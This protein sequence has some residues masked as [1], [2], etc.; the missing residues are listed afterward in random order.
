[1]QT[2]E[3]AAVAGQLNEIADLLEARHENEF[4]V[5]AYRVAART[6][7][8][9]PQPVSRLAARGE[10][11]LQELPGIGAHLARVIKQ[12]AEQGYTG[13]I[14][15]LVDETPPEAVLQLVPTIGPKLAQRF[16]D[17]LGVTTLAELEKA[18]ASGKVARM[19]GL[20]T[21]R[22]RALE[23]FFHDPKHA[24]APVKRPVPP[25][26]ELLDI[27]A[28][29]RRRAQDGDLPKLAPRR[30]NPEHT[31]WLPVLH[32]KRAG[33]RYTALYSNTQRAHEL[34]KEHDWVVI[35]ADDDDGQWTVVTET[36]GRLEGHR[37]VRG[38][39]R[40]CA[41]LLPDESDLD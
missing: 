29:Y 17:E 31:A 34:H 13:M 36:Q 23:E 18:V 28:E 25:V 38:R 14:G 19:D 15:R 3:N 35:Y 37:C 6:V 33:R 30:N 41:A 8:D 4:R 12:L 9:L 20:G 5:H 39:E 40:E 2:A 16:H 26:E 10:D 27:D 1:M 22:L 11:A 32:T 7:R 21:K 24:R